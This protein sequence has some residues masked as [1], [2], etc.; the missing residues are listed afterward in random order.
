MQ[1]SVCKKI[2][3]DHY[4]FKKCVRRNNL[5]AL[6]RVE[7]QKVR[8]TSDDMGRM[9]ANRK[10][11]EFV[12]LGITASCDAYIDIDPLGLA[13]QRRDKGSDIF[14]IDVQTEL[15]SAQNFVQFSEYCE[16]E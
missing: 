15:L 7:R 8:A 6:K 4:A 14:L 2:W 16:G 13:R 5:N 3:P 1:K 11:E 12:V 9:A 10:F